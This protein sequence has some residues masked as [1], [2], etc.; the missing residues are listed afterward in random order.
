MKEETTKV[1]C[2]S[3]QKEVEVKPIPFGNGHVASC[4]ECG[5]LAYNGK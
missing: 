5:K 3:C 1:V 2:L 4:P